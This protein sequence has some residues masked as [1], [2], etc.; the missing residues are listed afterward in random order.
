MK[1]RP[2]DNANY[3]RDANIGVECL[4]TGLADDVYQEHK[5]LRLGN[6]QQAITLLTATASKPAFGYIRLLSLPE[7]ISERGN[8]EFGVPQIC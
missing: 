7:L 4:W 1:E 3:G 2:C 6:E 8:V 5:Q